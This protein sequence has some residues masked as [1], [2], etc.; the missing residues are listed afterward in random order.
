MILLG[1]QLIFPTLDSHSTSFVSTAWPNDFTSLT[2]IL[3]TLLTLTLAHL[4]LMPDLMILLVLLLIFPTLDSL[5]NSFAP[6]A[7]PNDF[8]SLTVNLPHSWLSL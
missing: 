8:S 3:H 4:Y 7:W 2:V 1:L 6:T 5:S